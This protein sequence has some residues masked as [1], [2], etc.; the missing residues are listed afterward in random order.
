MS[1]GRRG[2][3]GTS[4]SRPARGRW[5]HWPRLGSS[6][7]PAGFAQRLA[8]RRLAAWARVTAATGAP[9][10]QRCTSTPGPRKAVCMV[11]CDLDEQAAGVA[12]LGQPPLGPAGAGGRLGRDQSQVGPDRAAGQPVPAPRTPTRPRSRKSWVVLGALPGSGTPANAASRSL[13]R[14]SPAWPEGR[15]SI[16]NAASASLARAP[17][18]YVGVVTP[19]LHGPTRPHTTPPSAPALRH[20]FTD[21]FAGPWGEDAGGSLL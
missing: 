20:A 2:R 10:W 18:N 21:D 12:G 13:R 7:G 6:S 4:T 19:I 8:R 16:E 14:A 17:M 5:R 9:S 11:P 1:P 3:P 15:N